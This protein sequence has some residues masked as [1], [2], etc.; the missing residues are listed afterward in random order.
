MENVI[1][2]VRKVR[3]IIIDKINKCILEVREDVLLYVLKIEI[4]SI[5]L[6]KIRDVIGVGG[7]VINKII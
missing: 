5:N 3:L 1:R 6:D 7:K 2:D 4:M